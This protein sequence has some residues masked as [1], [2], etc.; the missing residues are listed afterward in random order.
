[1]RHPTNKAT[2]TRPKSTNVVTNG[3]NEADARRRATNADTNG[4]NGADAR[5]RE[6]NADT[7]IAVEAITKDTDAKTATS[8]TSKTVHNIH[9]D[10]QKMME[11]RT[12]TD[13]PN[14]YR[15]IKLVR[16]TKAEKPCDKTENQIMHVT[17]D[18]QK[19]TQPQSEP[20]S[21]AM[22]DNEPHPQ[23]LDAKETVQARKSCTNP[24]GTLK[25]TSQNVDGFN[26][27][28]RNGGMKAITKELPD[29]ISLQE[30]KL[31]VKKEVSVETQ[32]LRSPLTRDTM[33]YLIDTYPYRLWNTNN[34]SGLHGTAML[35]KIPWTEITTQTGDTHADDEG[36][37]IIAEFPHFTLVNSYAQQSGLQAENLPKRDVYMGALSALILRLQQQTP[38]KHVILAGDLNATFAETDGHVACNN[39]PGY[40]PSERETFTKWAANTN[41]KDAWLHLGAKSTTKSINTWKRKRYAEDIQNDVGMRIDHVLVT[42][43]MLEPTENGVEIL[44]VILIQPCKVET[45]KRATDH[46][47]ISYTIRTQ[48][49][50]HWMSNPAEEQQ[51]PVI[52]N[53]TLTTLASLLVTNQIVRPKITSTLDTQKEWRTNADIVKSYAVGQRVPLRSAIPYVMILINMRNTRAMV[54]SGAAVSIA[55]TAFVHANLGLS[56]PQEQQYSEWANLSPLFEMAGGQVST[57]SMYVPLT[58]TAVDPA[59]QITISKTHWIW[60]IENEK[61]ELIIGSDFLSKT[62]GTIDY[63]NHTLSLLDDRDNRVSL[64]W[65]CDT[66]EPASHPTLPVTIANINVPVIA[67][68]TYTLPRG[69][70]GNIPAQLLHELP[71][72]HDDKSLLVGIAERN[73]NTMELGFVAATTVSKLGLV[74]AVRILNCT[75]DDIVI[76]KGTTIATYTSVPLADCSISK[77]NLDTLATARTKQTRSNVRWDQHQQ[78]K[79]SRYT[80]RRNLNIDTQQGVTKKQKLTPTT[81]TNKREGRNSKTELSCDDRA[82]EYPG[83]EGNATVLP[84]DY[85]SPRAECQSASFAMSDQQHEETQLDAMTDCE[86]DGVP[87]GLHNRRAEVS[88]TGVREEES[89]KDDLLTVRDPHRINFS[90]CEVPN[91]KPNTRKETDERQREIEKSPNPTVGNPQKRKN[92]DTKPQ[93]KTASAQNITTDNHNHG[94]TP[95]NKVKPIAISEDV[96]TEVVN[97]QPRM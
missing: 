39:Y 17:A 18:T 14:T 56:A 78:R 91:N 1:M 53:N 72:T 76:P 69:H 26:S 8:I 38:H 10:R 4:S 87:Q 29:I 86:H 43:A 55:T 73:N 68:N 66:P 74:A 62:R 21:V 24:I 35:S 37:T 46:V 40:R 52:D 64:P 65:I 23:I 41:L 33:Q 42:P 48:G 5:R 27:F 75:D 13:K 90:R 77:V 79:Q 67:S 25:L 84:V 3:S 83:D 88:T 63:N 32:L 2:E 57:A 6:P 70:E 16:K 82:V 93:N 94:I 20:I 96:T 11:L 58:I 7:A 49:P 95:L 81:H 97:P 89:A 36:R 15:P 19:P 80:P 30:V 51:L 47:L 45:D 85:Q 54:D 34:A 71:P 12:Q 22:A 28:I 50:P 60:V 92:T 44:E 9:P 31:K 59:S 61:A